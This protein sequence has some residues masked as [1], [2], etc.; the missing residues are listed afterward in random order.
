MDEICKSWS[1]KNVMERWK[2]SN[3][4]MAVSCCSFRVIM[5][6]VVFFTLNTYMTQS[7]ARFIKHLLLGEVWII[8]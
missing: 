4:C 3:N 5:N 2:S 6:A 8:C 1:V 7:N